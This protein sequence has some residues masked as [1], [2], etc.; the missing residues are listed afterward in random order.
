MTLQVALVG[1]D[2]I[3]LAS[4]LKVNTNE[5]NFNSTCLRSKF[6]INQER[7]MAACWSHDRDVSLE[8]IERIMSGMSDSDF[9]HPHPLVNESAKHVLDAARGP[10]D[11]P[12]ELEIAIV[13]LTDR[14]RIYEITATDKN[15]RCEECLDKAVFGNSANP[16]RYFLERYYEK[17]PIASLIPLAAHV[18]VNAGRLNPKGIE[19]LEIVQCRDTGFEHLKEDEINRLVKWSEGIDRKIRR[20]VLSGPK[21]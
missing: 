7:K 5:N 14:P 8:L 10:Y 20:V 13:T 2:G 15:C 19:G 21:P 3:V 18:V 6:S 12:H 17:G 11:T 1:M 16:A 4:D 9:K